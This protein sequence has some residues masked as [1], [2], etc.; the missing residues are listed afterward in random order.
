ME[1]RKG[2]E[3]EIA[4]LLKSLTQTKLE[5]EQLKEV[6]DVARQQYIAMEAKQ[7]SCDLE[8]ESLR[9]Q[10]RVINIG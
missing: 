3:G 9:H 1:A 5:N 7:K 10:V 6:S 2:L 8:L 4:S